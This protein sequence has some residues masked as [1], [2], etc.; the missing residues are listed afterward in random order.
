MVENGIIKKIKI[1]Q[2]IQFINTFTSIHLGN[3][4][5]HF[6][7]MHLGDCKSGKHCPSTL[8]I[9]DANTE[10]TSPRLAGV[11]HSAGLEHGSGE[12]NSLIQDYWVET[13]GSMVS[14]FPLLG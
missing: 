12:C 8:S 3:N 13:V 6:L 9:K 14:D 7:N 10:S 5:A 1:E 4:S 11:L 2:H